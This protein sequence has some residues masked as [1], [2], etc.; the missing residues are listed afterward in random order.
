MPYILIAVFSYWFAGLSGIPNYTKGVLS[1][2]GINIKLRP[3]DCERCLAYWLA[4][5]FYLFP[6]YFPMIIIYAGC[7]S[8]GAILLFTLFNRIR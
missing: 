2:F 3:F 6:N 7:A 8:F 5:W 4:L 1:N